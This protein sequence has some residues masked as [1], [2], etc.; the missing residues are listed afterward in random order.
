MDM[1]HVKLMGKHAILTNTVPTAST[2]RNVGKWILL[3]TLFDGVEPFWSEAFR[4][5]E[6]F[7]ITM[8]MVDI[9]GEAGALR[10]GHIVQMS[11][12]GGNSSDHRHGRVQTERFLDDQIQI[13]QFVEGTKKVVIVNTSGVDGMLNT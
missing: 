4:I 1:I 2:E 11:I 7:R 10:D 5:F 8:H 6:I 13:A 9:Y 3:S 12:L